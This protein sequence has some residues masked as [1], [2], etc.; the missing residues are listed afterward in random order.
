MLRFSPLEFVRFSD[1][2]NCAICHG[3]HI[4]TLRQATHLQDSWRAV[5]NMAKGTVI[6]IPLL[7]QLL[8]LSLFLESV[9]TKLSPGSDSPYQEHPGQQYLEIPFQVPQRKPT[10]ARIRTEPSSH[11]IS[12]GV[13]LLGPT[14]LGQFKVSDTKGF[15]AFSISI[16]GDSVDWS[17]YYGI[18]QVVACAPRLP[19]EL[20]QADWFHDG[21]PMFDHV[22]MPFADFAANPTF[23]DGP[24]HIK[25]KWDWIA[26][27]FIVYVPDAVISRQV[28]PILGIEWGYWIDNS[29]P[30][31][32]ETKHV[33]V[34]AWNEHLQLL[35]NGFPNW[36][37]DAA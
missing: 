26:R 3:K 33:N 13:S 21:R 28:K 23:F 14:A 20:S 10:I 11:P 15:P 24:F 1:G 37:F 2:V 17:A 18:I 25:K 12:M 16:T 8:T 36:T 30:Y 9:S 6:R 22:N 34:E 31:V 27:A 35:R 4:T 5:Y 7:M 29:K 32:K 19:R